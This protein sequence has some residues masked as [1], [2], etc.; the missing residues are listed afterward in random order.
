MLIGKSSYYAQQAHLGFPNNSLA[1]RK[2]SSDRSELKQ[3]EPG[4]KYVEHCPNDRPDRSPSYANLSLHNGSANYDRRDYELI[5]QQRHGLT[6]R[7]HVAHDIGSSYA[8][9]SCAIYP[10]SSSYAVR[11]S[12][13]SEE[14]AAGSEPNARDQRRRQ[15]GAAFA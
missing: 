8:N 5:N 14:H 10:K 11:T 7:G 15:G 12:T 4:R 13:L 9:E 3:H 6:L 1:C 2:R